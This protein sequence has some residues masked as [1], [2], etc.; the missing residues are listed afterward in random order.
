MAYFSLQVRIHVEEAKAG[1]HSGQE[2]KQDRG[3][4]LP[5]A[6]LQARARQPFAYRPGVALP[7]VLWALPH[8]SQLRK[9]HPDMPTGQSKGGDDSAEVCSS[10]VCQADDQD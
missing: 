9:C 6:V 10:Q 5:T 8:P 1:R 3:G 4:T 7:T 2:P